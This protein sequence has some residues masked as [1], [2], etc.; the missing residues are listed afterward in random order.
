MMYEMCAHRMCRF[1]ANRYVSKITPISSFTL[2]S[3]LPSASGLRW[4]LITLISG[5]S[6]RV[7]SSGCSMRVIEA[8]D[9]YRFYHIGEEETL[10]LRGVSLHVE[11][12]EIVTV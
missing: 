4:V 6:C 3:W 9:L 7:V 11:A 10:A 8:F 2:V 5:G 1:T 12:G